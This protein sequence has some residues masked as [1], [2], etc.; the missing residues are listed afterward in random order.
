MVSEPNG[1]N[2]SVTTL[3]EISENKATLTTT[4]SKETTYPSNTIQTSVVAP[5]SQN[6]IPGE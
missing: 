4:S 6:Q 3:T 5:S 2:A 1:T